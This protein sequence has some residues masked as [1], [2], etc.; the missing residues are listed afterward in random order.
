MKEP[1]R[2]LANGFVKKPKTPESRVFA[3]KAK[4]IPD[5]FRARVGLASAK[6]FSSIETSERSRGFFT[7]P[8]ARGSVAIALISCTLL[9]HDREGVVEL[10]G[11]FT[12]GFSVAP[13]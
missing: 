13:Y 6:F 9:S 12:R 10:N 4:C 5:A 11:F 1:A 3:A 7:N 2:P 8:N